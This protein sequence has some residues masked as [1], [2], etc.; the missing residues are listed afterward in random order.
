VTRQEETTVI[1]KYETHPIADTYPL[2]SEAELDALTADI[3]GRG[4]QRPVVRYQGKI[5]DGRNRL[6]ACE[7]AGIEPAFVDYEGD[8]PEGQARSLNLNR[9]LTSAQRAMVA[10]RQLPSF[11]AEARKR[12]EA[13]GKAGGK[14]GGRGRKK[15]NPY[16]PKVHKGLGTARAQAAD[17]FGV[18]ERQVRQAVDLLDEAPDLASQV[19][20]GILL[21]APAYE[22]LETR[23]KEAARKAADQA[24]ITKYQD[25]VREGEM[26]L[27]Q[28]LEKVVAEER[29]AA[30]ERAAD[31]D[32]REQWLRRFAA[33][34]EWAEE[35][36]IP[37]TDEH[38]LWYT[39]P[40]SP[41]LYDHGITAE[42]VDAAITGLRR[43][44]RLTFGDRNGQ[45]QK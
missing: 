30:E 14:E 42:R 20:A 33:F 39:E 11:Q 18:G 26:T 34:L 24:R 41:G 19:A 5:L 43:A 32:A 25:A 10:A 7:R 45:E 23:R 17:H 12:Q 15:E 27:E 38:L 36:V 22:K 21:L 29:E 28:A 2:M 40:D 1:G 13:A 9:N 31:A 8:D 35:Y 3:A 44:A 4:L 16:G 37:P 6:V